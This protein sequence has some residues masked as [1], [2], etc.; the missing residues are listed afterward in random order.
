MCTILLLAEWISNL[1]YWNYI[2]VVFSLKVG[3]SFAAHSSSEEIL[4]NVVWQLLFK[5]RELVPLVNKS[6]RQHPTKQQLYGH[7]LPITKTIQVRRTKHARHCW[8]SKEKLIKD[9]LLTTPSY[10]WASVGRPARTYLQQIC[11][12]AGCR[13]EEL[14]GAMDGCWESARKILASSSTWWW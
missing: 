7:L 14:S 8:R 2:S 10:G 13:L 9:V 5:I 3:V 12:D 4:G 1:R 6:W 11:A